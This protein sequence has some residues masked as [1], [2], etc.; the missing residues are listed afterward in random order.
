M[1]NHIL[2]YFVIWFCLWYG[3]RVQ[4]KVLLLLIIIIII[5]IKPDTKT[6]ND[7]MATS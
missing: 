6:E 2:G 4:N 1:A 3:L 5:W 7:Q